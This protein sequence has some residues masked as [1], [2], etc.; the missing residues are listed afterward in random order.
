MTIDRSSSR[1]EM[2][3]KLGVLK[4]FIKLTENDRL[5]Y[6]CFPV[7]FKNV[8][9][10]PFWQSTYGRTLL[11]WWEGL[12]LP[13]A[14]FQFWF[15]WGFLRKQTKWYCSY[16]TRTPMDAAQVLRET[17]NLSRF[18]YVWGFSQKT[19][20]MILALSAKSLPK[21]NEFKMKT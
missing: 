8:F 1:L 6:K 11:K 10:T 4:N 21:V 2:F 13:S 18:S 17:E 3:C 9:R 14:I 16:Q 20:R 12:S 5:P 15:V 7:N 19:N